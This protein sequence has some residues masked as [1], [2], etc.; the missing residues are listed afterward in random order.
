MDGDDAT[1]LA[2]LLAVLAEDH[3]LGAVDEAVGHGGV[4][5]A[6]EG[7]VAGLQ[8]LFGSG[9]RGDDD[10]WDAAEV[11]EHDGTVL[12]GEFLEDAVGEGACEL[13]EIAN[14]R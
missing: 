14:E 9:R 1:E 13:V 7:D 2:P 6:G 3:A 8:H 10:G 12:G 4:R 11:E 5:A